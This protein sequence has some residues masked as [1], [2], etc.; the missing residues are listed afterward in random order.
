M[1]RYT[2]INTHYLRT[3]L[4][5][6]RRDLWVIKKR[7]RGAIQDSATSLIIQLLVFG[8][9]LPLMGVSPTL[10][11]P[12][13]IGAQAA[14]MFFLG[15]GFG[16]RTIFDIKYT[17]FIDYRLTL[18]L[19]KR[20][21]FASYITYFMMEAMIISGPLLTIGIITLGPKFQAINPNWIIF[22]GIYFMAL[23]F[24]GLMFLGLSLHYEYD[25]FMQNLWP[26][27]LTVL[28]AF[29]PLFFIWHSVHQ[30][31]PKLAY[32][33]L[34]NPLTSIAEGLRTTLIGGS[35]FLP[36]YLCAPLLAGWIA[37][38]ICFVYRSMYKRLDPV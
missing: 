27:R 33:M 10:I 19:P 22:I 9:F 13:F 29:S 11:A 1:K 16:L 32:A 35:L 37:L 24:Y 31:S 5:L 3:Y 23:S 18:P 7:Y 36:V 34:A 15:M 26:R 6:V 17:R 20:W 25:W 38:M 21:L 14:S 4:A 12:L 30:F 28:F 8:S 2:L